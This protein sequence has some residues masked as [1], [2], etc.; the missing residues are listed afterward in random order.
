[1]LFRSVQ[2]FVGACGSV[3][4]ALHQYTATRRSSL[5]YYQF[6]TR[7]LTPFFQSGL[8]PLG[9]LRDAFMGPTCHIP[10]VRGRMLKTM[11]GLETGFFSRAHAMPALGGGGGPGALSAGGA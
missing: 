8:A 3:D 6:A 1:V 5:R 7:W 11:G 2:R 10:Y 4:E 9:W